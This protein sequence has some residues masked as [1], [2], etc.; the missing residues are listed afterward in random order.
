MIHKLKFGW[1]I[2]T[3]SASLMYYFVIT[4]GVNLCDAKTRN[5]PLSFFKKSQQ[6]IILL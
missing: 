5:V 4:L 1:E 3:M 2:E 6:E